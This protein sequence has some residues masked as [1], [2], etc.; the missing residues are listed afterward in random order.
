M[1]PSSLMS[2]D[3]RKLQV[4]SLADSLVEDVYKVSESFPVAERFGLQAQLRRAA[5]STACNIVEGCA[6]R[7]TKE[8]PN[9]LNVAAG[10]SAE[11]RYLVD[12]A[13][14]LRFLTADTTDSI[15]PRYKRLCGQLQ[16][17][18]ASLSTQAERDG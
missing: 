4:F 3:H 17:L 16:T 12:L 9:F 14:R 6:R 2:R 1:L 15:E 8:Y 18:I 11:A 7:T 5:V 10:S 13:R